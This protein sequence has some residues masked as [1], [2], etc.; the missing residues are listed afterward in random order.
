MDRCIITN[1]LLKFF[2]ILT[3]DLYVAMIIVKRVVFGFVCLFAY[4]IYKFQQR[5]QSLDNDIEEFLHNHQNLQP[6]KYSYSDIKKTTHN[7]KN[8]LGQG[9][10]YMDRMIFGASTKRRELAKND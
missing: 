3:C 2:I 9:C 6:I 7:F 1:I 8:K 10:G 5:H 4:L